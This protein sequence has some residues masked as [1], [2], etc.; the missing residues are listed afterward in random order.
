MYQGAP[1]NFSSKKIV[2]REIGSTANKHADMVTKDK[3]LQAIQVKI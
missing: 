2:L 3:W 1:V